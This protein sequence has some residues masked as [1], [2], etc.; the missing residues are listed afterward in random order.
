MGQ[1]IRINCCWSISISSVFSFLFA[2]DKSLAQK[3]KKYVQKVRG[4]KEEGRY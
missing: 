1:S 2:G 4:F 3:T